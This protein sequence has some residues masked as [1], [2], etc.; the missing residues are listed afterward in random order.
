M[1]KILVLLTFFAVIYAAK[2]YL[3]NGDVL[4]GEILRYEDNSAVIK[5]SYGEMKI[6]QDQ[7]VKIEF[8]TVPE[9]KQSK[10]PDKPAEKSE[11]RLFQGSI[12]LY[13]NDV[14]S[15]KYRFAPGD[16]I[17]VF[18]KATEEKPTGQAKDALDAIAK[19]VAI[20]APT[21]SSVEIADIDGQILAQGGGEKSVKIAYRTYGERSISINFTND[22]DDVIKTYDVEIIRIPVAE[23]LK[24][25]DTHLKVLKKEITKKILE[26]EV[27]IGAG[28]KILENFVVEDT[29]KIVII[30]SN[31]ESY[32]MLT[33]QLGGSLVSLVLS[34]ATDGLFSVDLTKIPTGEDF[35]YYVQY[36]HPQRNKWLYYCTSSSTKFEYRV[37]DMSEYH[38]KSW[39]IWLDNSYSLFTSKDIRFE[40]YIVQSLDQYE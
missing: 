22:M 10:V 30:V 27:H 18:V 35:G 6:S 9:Q 38:F 36:W 5:T 29:G 39:C 23:S 7:I 40:I 3:K 12:E 15:K 34:A 21:V 2:I 37:I 13:P 20:L 4:T 17:I 28:E 33:S 1:K 25:F 24:F 19:I 26:K 14:E 8:E 16:S 11:I 31:I 32:N